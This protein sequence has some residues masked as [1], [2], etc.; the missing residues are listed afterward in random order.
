MFSV[1]S[2]L[3]HEN[4]NVDRRMDQKEREQMIK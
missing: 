1:D 3:V 4:I 2:E